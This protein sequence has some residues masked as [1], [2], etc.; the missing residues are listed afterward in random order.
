MDDSR[1][2]VEKEMEKAIEKKIEQEVEKRV[3]EGV[4]VAIAILIAVAV[5]F[6][7]SLVVFKFVWAWVVPDLFPG[8]VAQ[9][10]VSANLTWFATVKLAVLVAAL[11]GF[12][13]ALI[14]AFRSRP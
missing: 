10:L 11:S 6:V 13:P 1:S 5:T 3:T 4:P 14:E 9:G 8:A 7:I 12:Y 2:E